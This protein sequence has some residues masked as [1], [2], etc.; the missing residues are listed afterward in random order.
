MSVLIGDHGPVGDKGDSKCL[1]RATSMKL[2]LEIHSGPWNSWQS[3]QHNS[4]CTSKPV[5]YAEANAHSEGALSAI[6]QNQY[7]E[8]I[9]QELCPQMAMGTSWEASS[10]R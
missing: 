5:E 3:V 2:E 7:H 9:A 1:Y 4:R 8:F 6:D 10:I